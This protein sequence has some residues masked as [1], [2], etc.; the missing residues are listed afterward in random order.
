MEL[1]I[2]AIHEFICTFA[3]FTKF[4]AGAHSLWR[5]IATSALLVALPLTCLYFFLLQAS[6]SLQPASSAT[7]VSFQNKQDHSLLSIIIIS[8]LIFAKLLPS[9][10]YFFQP[11]HNRPPKAEQSSGRA[12]RFF[13]LDRRVLHWPYRIVYSAR[14][15]S[16]EMRYTTL[17]ANKSEGVRVRQ[18]VGWIMIARN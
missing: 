10:A 5:L 18:R 17:S 11:Q 3:S 1:C 6:T 2:I 14:T 15:R 8:I 13:H 9:S 7:F 4:V 12:S 16:P